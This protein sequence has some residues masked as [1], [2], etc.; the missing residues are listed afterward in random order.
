VVQTI[1]FIYLH[2]LLSSIGTPDDSDNDEEVQSKLNLK[3]RNELRFGFFLLK[4]KS[5]FFNFLISF[6][7]I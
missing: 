7:F 3:G 5:D 4:R 2:V 1:P 6:S